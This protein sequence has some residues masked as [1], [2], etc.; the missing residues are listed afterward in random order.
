MRMTTTD[1]AE[2]VT[3]LTR[4]FFIVRDNS[5]A[6]AAIYNPLPGI[7]H[8]GPLIISGR[9]SGAIMPKEVMLRANRTQFATVPVDPY[10]LFY[11]EY[12]SEGIQEDVNLVFSASFNNPTGGLITSH[13]HEVQVHRYGA[14]L[15]VD[16]HVDGDSITQRPWLSGRAWYT[17]EYREQ[18]GDKLTWNERR[19]YDVEAVDV[20]YDNGRTY[21]RAVGKENW[22]FRLETGEMVRGPLPVLI[23]ATFAN[24]SVA[25]RRLILIVDV[26]APE[27]RILDPIE[28][29][30]HRDTLN[31][32]GIASDD[33]QIADLEIQLRPGDK[34]GY[35]LP[36]FVQG[37]YLDTNI[38]GATYGDIGLG[39]SFFENN[40]KLQFQF[41][42]AP[43]GQRFTGN[44]FGFKLLANIL[45]LP[46]DY[47]FGPDWQPFSMAFALGANFSY[48]TMEGNPINN[49]PMLL[50][51]VLAQWEML[52]VTLSES[53]VLVWPNSGTSL[54]WP[55]YFSFY[56]EP[57]WWFASS[58]VADSAKVIFRATLGI[59]VGVL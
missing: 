42:V 37:M 57:I 25:V 58:D 39:L 5:I 55:K 53:E 28:N 17:D 4:N 35:S 50:G 45:Y 30:L 16:S 41:G 49:T 51:A 11:Y 27:V 3:L 52:R 2:N 32:Y 48:F 9:V 47:F 10:G 59:K 18:K 19:F 44:V 23:K 31:I 7:D 15:A 20:S 33:Y 24:G 13:D 46:M 8:T 6:E 43:E 54:K 14:A 26:D 29:S 21:Q 40:V 36:K 38:F 56:L 22:K 1:L 12:P 34:V